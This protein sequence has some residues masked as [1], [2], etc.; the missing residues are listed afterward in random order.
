MQAPHILMVVFAR[1]M[2]RQ[3]YTRIYFADEAANADDPDPRAGAGGAA[4][5]ADRQA[6]GAGTAIRSIRSTSACRATSETVFFE[7]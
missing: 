4:R 3:S 6:D 1:G 7:V 5:H 2:L